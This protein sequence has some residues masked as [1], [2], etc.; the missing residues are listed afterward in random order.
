MH[1]GL[2]IHGSAVGYDCLQG[3]ED[4]CCWKNTDQLLRSLV[5]KEKT[6]LKVWSYDHKFKLL[7]VVLWDNNNI[8]TT[9]STQHQ[10]RL[11]WAGLGLHRCLLDND[12]F[13][14]KG[15]TPVE[16][17]LQTK[18]YVNEYDKI[19]KIN[20]R[21]AKFNLKGNSK[22]HARSL[23]LNNWYL[24][25]H[26]GNAGVFYKRLHTLYTPHKRL[27]KPREQ[28]ADVTYCLCRL[29]PNLRSPISRYQ[30]WLWD[31]SHVYHSGFGRKVRRDCQGV[32]MAIVP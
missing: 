12:R 18:K 21:N 31:L 11:L 7:C 32:H 26:G 23:K 20:L 22:K 5:M 25:T 30:P 16:I 4:Q 10:P 29:G 6:K 9:L 17:P 24:N 2:C 28:M 8:V 19:D 27:L 3:V 1:H 14:D 15:L 13:W